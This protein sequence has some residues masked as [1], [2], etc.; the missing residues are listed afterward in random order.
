MI[1]QNYYENNED[2][3]IPLIHHFPLDNAKS[4]LRNIMLKRTY[5]ALTLLIQETK[6]EIEHLESIRSSL[7]I[8][9][10]EHDLADL[11]QE[12][13]EYG[14]IRENL[15]RRNLE[16]V[17]IK[18]RPFHY[19]SSDGYDIYVGKNNYQ[20]EELTFKLA[21]GSDWWF[22]AKNLPTPMS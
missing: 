4:I 5:E 8:A 19:K 1:T 15:F 2:I 12:L 14:Y 17:K 6:D 20:N 3:R 18:S 7:E 22:H 21:E 16:R 9:T 10:D 13:I 11:K